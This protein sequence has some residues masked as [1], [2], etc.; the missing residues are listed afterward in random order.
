VFTAKKWMFGF[1]PD[2]SCTQAAGSGYCAY[3]DAG[4]DFDSGG[5][6]FPQ[7]DSPSPP[8][9][10]PPPESFCARL[11]QGGSQACLHMDRNLTVL[12]V[13]DDLNDELL[14]RKA[15]TREGINNPIHV[16]NDGT[17]AIQYLQGEGQYFDRLQFPFPSVIF[18]DLKMA[19]MDGFDILRWLRAHPECSVM[20][21]IILTASKM[22][23][24]IK[25]AYQLGANA[26]LVKPTK[27]EDLQAMV[28]AA[29]EFWAWCEKP[30]VGVKC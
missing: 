17:E 27:L 13:E 14:L 28:R 26:Y 2:I 29:Y 20:P 21:L 11:H 19:H 3:R 7:R 30:H 24:D 9:W 4:F 18:T 16:V 1:M 5:R 6:T 10:R 22:D 8:P 12:I 23:A 15:L 25:K